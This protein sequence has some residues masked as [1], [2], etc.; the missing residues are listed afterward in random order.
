MGVSELIAAAAA[1]QAA[2]DAAEVP[3]CVI[4]GPSR[5]H[6]GARPV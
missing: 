5:S 6:G 3:N 4:G 1:V 2:L